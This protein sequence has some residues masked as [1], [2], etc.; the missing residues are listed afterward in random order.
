[1][2]SELTVASNPLLDFPQPADQQVLHDLQM[3]RIF[4]D[5]QV[6]REHVLDAKPIVDVVHEMLI[7]GLG[8]CVVAREAEQ[9]W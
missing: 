5:M 4:R 2:T 3:A 7:A 8:E 1:M 6:D 9:G